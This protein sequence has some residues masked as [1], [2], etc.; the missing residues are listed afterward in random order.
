M[1]KVTCPVHQIGGM[2]K[3]DGQPLFAGI[4]AASALVALREMLEGLGVS[5]AASFRTHDFRRGHALDLQLSG[6]FSFVL[7]HV[8]VAIACL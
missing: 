7:A 4:T 1:C 5:N 3:N 8:V 6:A 2:L